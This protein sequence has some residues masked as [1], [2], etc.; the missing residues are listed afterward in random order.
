ML[1][2]VI[3]ARFFM[4]LVYWQNSVVIFEK[5]YLPHMTFFFYV[6]LR[7]D[8]SLSQESNKIEFASIRVL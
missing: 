6:I 3:W 2:N 1:R 5:S 7:V 8:R 4:K